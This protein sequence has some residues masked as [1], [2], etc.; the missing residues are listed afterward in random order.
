MLY[1]TLRKY[2]FLILCMLFVHTASAQRRYLT[3]EW[4][5]YR[6]AELADFS[7]EQTNNHTDAFWGLHASQ[8]VGVH[9]LFGVSMEGAWSSYA[10][11]MQIASIT[12]GGSAV[13][14]H[15]VY[16]FQYSGFLV[17]TG[18]GINA[19]QVYNH[20]R[21]SDMYHYGMQDKWEGVEPADYILKH[22]FRN[23]QDR[24]R[25]I[26]GQLPLYVGHYIVGPS[27]VGYWLLGLQLNYAFMGDTRQTLL[28]TTMADYEPFLGIWHEM[29]NHGYR[30]DVPLERNGERLKLKLDVLLHGEMGYEISTYHGPHNY[31]RTQTSGSDWRFRFAGFVDFGMANINPRTRNVLYG[32][33]EESIYDFP[34]YRMDHVFSTTDTKDFWMRN[35]YAGV[36]ITILYGIPW[37][38]HCILCDPWKH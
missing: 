11:N 36:R 25:N 1:R 23:R 34:T 18:I 32:V 35:L 17:Q 21:D 30:Q 26:Y 29:D 5:E 13:G 24:S 16:E 8:Y 6:L 19:Q 12:P 3:T 37:K 2:S 27:G 28:G 20:V 33:P 4:W 15:F 10:N 22:E 9:H 14:L 7:F 38:E 31:R